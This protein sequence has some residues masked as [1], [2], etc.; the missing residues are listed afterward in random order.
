MPMDCFYQDGGDDGISIGKGV[1][2]DVLAN[3]ETLYL[4]KGN[5]GGYRRGHSVGKRYVCNILLRWAMF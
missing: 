1:A 4:W 2:Q 5:G 3:G